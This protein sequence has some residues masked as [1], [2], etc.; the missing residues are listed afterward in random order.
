VTFVRTHNAKQVSGRICVSLNKCLVIFVSA[1]PS[2]LS[3]YHLVEPLSGW[4]SVWSN[5][6]L[7]ELEYAKHSILSN[8]HLVEPLYVEQVSGKTS[9]RPN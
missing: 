2:V 4:T 7:V 9:F 6:C 8:Y 5:K 3:N 1:K